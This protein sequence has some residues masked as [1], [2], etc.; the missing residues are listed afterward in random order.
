MLVFGPGVGELVVVFVPPNEWLYIDSCS[1]GESYGL[2][3]LEHYGK[4]PSLVLLTHPHLDH[5][6]G[7]PEVLDHVLEGD[8]A[9]WPKL[10]FLPPA[11]YDADAETREVHH[12]DKEARSGDTEHAIAKIVQAWETNPA[13]RWS[14]RAGDELEIG[15]A[16]LKILSPSKTAHARG[17]RDPNRLSTAALLWWRGRRILLGSDLTRAGWTEALKS[18][19]ELVEHD[20]FK[21]PHHGSE[22]AQHPRFLDP[23]E[24]APTW[25]LTPFGG[26]VPK[27]G[28]GEDVDKMLSRVGSLHLTALPR[29]HGAQ[30]GTPLS[31]TRASLAKDPDLVFDTQTS[32]FPDCFVA[33]VVPKSGPPRCIYGEGSVV[34]T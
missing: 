30:S 15:E 16:R 12:Y 6:G 20:V 26:R 10:G 14:P 22:N 18:D 32:G 8:S 9:E 1:V 4:Q 23:G 29:P 7:L 31:L 19:P 2:K 24:T 3:V 21:I 5:S 28:E 33:I 25:T 27:F 17:L 11:G 13:C 34:V